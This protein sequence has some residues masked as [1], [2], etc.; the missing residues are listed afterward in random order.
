MRSCSKNYSKIKSANVRFKNTRKIFHL[1]F[2]R[3]INKETSLQKNDH[4]AQISLFNAKLS[5]ISNLNVGICY[6][7]L[8][9]FYSISCN[10]VST[11]ERPLE[12]FYFPIKKGGSVTYTYTSQGSDSLDNQLWKLTY[13]E[14]GEKAG[15]KGEIIQS[16]GKITHSWEE[17]STPTGMIMVNYALAMNTKENLR[18]LT[19][20]HIVH[21]DIFPYKADIGGIF[22]FNLKWSDPADSSI[23]YELIRNRIFKGDTMMNVL[24][25]DYKAIHFKLKERVE[26]NNEGILG[27]DLS[28]EEYYAEGLGL[29]R[30][31]KDLGNKKT[32]IYNLSSIN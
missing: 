17:S 20:T 27:L 24:G 6:F 12:S 25:K 14:H 8:L 26:V 2:Y 5:D 29:V 4:R 9:I 30:Y 3:M 15:L 18:Q 32:I 22:L 16:D 11:M 23:K 1:Q 19:S 31:I 10:K 21:D 13:N 7:V 28:G